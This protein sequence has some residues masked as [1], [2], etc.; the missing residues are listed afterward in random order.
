MMFEYERRKYKHKHV[1][2]NYIDTSR[3]IIQLK[4]VKFLKQQFISQI[5]D[6]NISNINKVFCSSL[7]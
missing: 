4:K 3:I 7:F 1:N 5:M 2:K 6:T